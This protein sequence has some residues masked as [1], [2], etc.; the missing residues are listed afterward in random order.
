MGKFYGEVGY[1]TTSETVPGKWKVV[2]TEKKYAGDLTRISRIWQSGQK[3][4]DDMNISA[5]VSIIA[6][7][8]FQ[9]HMHEIRYI[10]FNGIPWE[11]NTIEPNYPKYTLM[12]GGVYNGDVAGN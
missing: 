8:Y 6:D 12:I 4:N 2:V 1:V 10:K 3:I 9:D 7:P 5:Q 11:V